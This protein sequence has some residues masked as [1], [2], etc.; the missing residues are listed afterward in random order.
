[1][2]VDI[3]GV[4]AKGMGILIS[5]SGI[6]AMAGSIF[7]ASLPNK[8][9]G[10][11]FILGSLILGLSL[12]G[13]S[14]SSYWFPAYA[15]PVA[16]VFIVFVGIGQTAR[17]TLGNTLLQYYVQDEYRGRVMSLYMMEFGLTSF[18]VFF[19]GI[20]TDIVGVRWSV[21]GLAIALVVLSI[22]MLIFMPR[23]RNL[24]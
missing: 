6:G 20:L 16:L 18:G 22:Y 17:M 2:T 13:F 15:W 1:M 7:L 19:A 12:V 3:Y 24:D 11:M 8:K 9:R 4:G 23:L 10:L 5:V 14:F 21:G